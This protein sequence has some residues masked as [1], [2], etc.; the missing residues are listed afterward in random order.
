MIT[1]REL[2]NACLGIAHGLD[3]MLP[4]LVGSGQ[5]VGFT[6]LLFEFGEK[7]NLAYISNAKRADMIQTIKEWLARASPTDRFV[8]VN[9]ARCRIWVG[10]SD[11]GVACHAHIALVGVARTEDCD[12]FSRELVEAK[13]KAAP[14]EFNVIPLRLIL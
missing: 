12:Q 7:G 5:R 1:R 11:S 13:P 3:E 4:K 9:G 10:H 14:A 8:D 6:L 2:E